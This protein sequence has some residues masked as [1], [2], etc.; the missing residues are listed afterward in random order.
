MS[1]RWRFIFGLLALTLLSPAGAHEGAMTGFADIRVDADAIRYT[2]TLSNLP[3]PAAADPASTATAGGADLSRLVEALAA[4]IQIRADGSACR[5]IGG[6]GL[7]AAVGRSSASITLHYRCPREV[8]ELQVRDGSFDIL[9]TGLHTLAK[10][11]WPGGNDSFAFSSERREARFVVTASA[12]PRGA[13]SFFVLGIEHILGGLDHLLFLAALL[14][15]AEA[16]IAALRVITAFTVAH[17][18]TLGLAVLGVVTP[19]ARLVEGAIALSVA[20]VALVNL[21]GRPGTA[22]RS[23]AAFLFGLVHGL[24][25]SGVLREMNLPD[26]DVLRLLLHFNLGVEAG[27][28]LAAGIALTALA[29]LRRQSWKQPA[30]QMASCLILATGVGM[31]IDRSLL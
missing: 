29:W 9:G 6:Q 10:V 1:L 16:W 24:G 8:R 30:L 15:R 17:S 31:F 22:S 7:P 14:I 23:G 11:G 4:A 19:P 26:D 18:L 21:V 25:F 13:G 27:Q 3:T 2:L 28:A 12:T 5:A 20:Y